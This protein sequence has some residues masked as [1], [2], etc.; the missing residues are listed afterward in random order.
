[1]LGSSQIFVG[2]IFA[3][4]IRVPSQIC[5]GLFP[6]QTC[7]GGS[8]PSQICG[9]TS[10]IRRK[11]RRQ[12]CADLCRILPPEIVAIYLLRIALADP[13]SNL[14]LLAHLLAHGRLS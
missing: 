14:V 13:T 7:D 6:S 11:V 12:I 5:D 2:E 3:T 8:S 10:I 1:M 4:D 9:R